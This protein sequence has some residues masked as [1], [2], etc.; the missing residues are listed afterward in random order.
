MHAATSLWISFRKEAVTEKHANATLRY[1][2]LDK[3]QFA[4]QQQTEH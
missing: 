2:I 1:K 4:Q 3:G